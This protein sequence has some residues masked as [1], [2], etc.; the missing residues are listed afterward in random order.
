MNWL[1]RTLTLLALICALGLTAFGQTPIPGKY[2]EYYTVAKT[3][4]TY[5]DLGGALAGPSIN[6]WREVAFY[7][8][9]AVFTKGA[10]FLGTGAAAAVNFNP[11]ETGSSDI[12]GAT[13]QV[14][15]NHQVAAE[16]RIT[17]TS[18][19][20][21]SI[22]LYNANATDSVSFIA[23]GGLGRAYDAV[24][25]NASVNLGG[26]V[27]YTGTHGLPAKVLGLLQHGN[28]TPIE[29]NIVNGNPKPMI[30]DDG[31]VVFANGNAPNNQI[32]VYPPGLGNPI[33][34]AD[35]ANHW[36]SLDNDPGISRDGRIVAFQGNI[37]AV[38]AAAIG[39]TNGPGIFVAVN[40]GAGFG[41]AKIIRITGGKVEDVAADR[42]AGKGNFDGV[43][44]A[45]EICKAAAELG[46]DNSGNPITIASYGTDSRVGVTNVDFGA[47]GIDDDSFVI[48]FIAT[49]SSASRDNPWQPGS[50]LV[51]SANTGLWTIRVDVQHQLTGPLGRVY[52][53]FT[54]IPVVQVGD[55][56]GADTVTAI[57]VYDPIAN[58]AHDENGN[59]RTM[60]R[61]DHRVAFWVSTAAGGQMII[62]ANHL[63]SDQDGLLD[64][65]ETTG[66]DMDQ[67]GIVDLRL[68][69]YGADPFTRDL[70]LQVDWIGKP[71]SDQFKPAGG[72]FPSDVANAYSLFE[73]NLRNAEVLS[74]PMF[75]AR[76]DNSPPADIKAGIVPHVDA[77]TAIDSLLLPMSLNLG[78]GAPH[79][80]NYVG[81][82]GDPN[83][84]PQVV[85]FGQ[86][87][88]TVAGVNVR[89]FQDIKDHFLGG[90]D[91]A[92]RFLAFHYTVFSPFQDFLP[93]YPA[94]PYSATITGGDVSSIEVNHPAASF[95]R[96]ADGAFLLVTSG[97]AIGTVRQISSVATSGVTG[98]AIFALSASLNPAP[99]LGDTVAFLDGS[100]GLAEVAF[101]PD[102]DN[103]SLPGNDFII[104]TGSMGVLQGVPPNLC[105][106]A[107]TASHELGHTLGLL[108]GGIDQDAKK[109]GAVFKSV[110]S[111]TW[112]LECNP[113][114][115][116]PFYSVSGD[117]T[118]DNYQHL[119]FNFPDVQFHLSTSLGEARGEGFPGDL[120]QQTPEQTL[121]DFIAKNG[122]L[123]T[124]PPT[125]GISSPANASNVVAGGTLTVNITASDN[126]AVSRVSASFDINGNGIIEAGEAINAT[127]T[128]ANT[129]QAV[130]P[131]V[132]G[133]VGARTVSAIAFD[134]SSNS[135]R[136]AISVNVVANVQ[137]AVPNVVGLTQVAATNAITNAGLVVGNVTQASSNT[138]AAGS[139]ISE[140]PVAGTLVNGGSSVDLVISTGPAQVQVPNVVGLTQAAATTAITNAGLV[141]GT[142]SQASSNTVAA[143][144]VIS[145][146]PVAGTSVNLGS[147]VNIVVSTGPAQ[148]QVPNVVGLTQA[149]ATTA[150]TNAGLVLGT[151]SQASSNTVAA[152]NVISESPVAGTSV[153]VGSSVN[154]VVSTGPAQV[155]VPNVV[156]L[157]QA[158]ATTAI[159]NAGLVLGTVSQASSNTVAAGNVI[160][161]SPVAGT[162]V[163]VGSS[164][165][166]VVSTGPAQ[167]QVPNVVGLTQA[168]ATTAI[169]NAGLVLG[170]VSQ[171]SSNT[172]AAGNVI[173]ESPVAGT[174]VNVGSSVNIV[175]STGPAQ[176]QVPN[177][178]G[179]TQAAATTAITNA[180]LV[181]GTV[182]QAS[183]NT[184]A[185]GNVISESPVAGTSVNSGSSVNIVVSTGPAQVQ[186][187]NVVGLTQAAATTAITN[188]GLVLGTVSQAASNTVAAGSVISESPVAGT[189]V[190]SGSSVNI[191]VS[192]G[193]AQ[194]Q[195]PNVVGLTQAAA[196][197]AITNAGLVLGT[198][199]QASSNTVAAGNVISES[200]VAGT[201]VNTGS[202]VN[203][204]V[205]TGPAQVQVPNVVGLT[206]AAATT[207]ITN[208]G[209][210][211]GTVTQASSNTVAAGNVIS[212][213][214]VA[215][216]S[217]NTGSSVN[218]VVS[219]GPAQVQVPNVVG[220]TQ[221]AA[222]TA[223]T[224][225]GLVLGTVSQASSNTV[226]AGNVISESPVAGTSVNSGSSVNIVVSTGP[227]QVQ[228][229]NVVGLTQAAATTA[230][231]NAGLV[232]GTVTQ[233]SSNTVAAGNVISE[234]P[235]AGTSVNTGS[236]VNIVV[237]TGPAQVQVPNVVGLTQAAATTAITNAGLVLGTV[238][239][240]SSNTVAA[241]NVISESPVAGTSVNPGSAVNIVVSTGPSQVQVPNVVGL[242]QAAA[243]TAITNAGLTVGGVSTSS[244]NT[245]AA[246]KVISENPAAGTTVNSGSAVNLVISTGPQ[247]A[248]PNVVGFTQAAAGTV[249]TNA[250][251][252]VGAISNQSSNTVAAG[253]VIS[254]N[255]PAAT[256]VNAGTPVSLVIS[257]G[258]A[259]PLT[260]TGPAA[261]PVG[262]AGAPYTATAITVTG[263]TGLG[264]YTWSASGLP[265]NL[266]ISLNTGIISGTPLA[267]TVNPLTVQV[268]VTDSSL[269][270][271]SKTYSLTITPPLVITGPATLPPATVGSAYST[272]VTATGG[273][274]IYIWSAN[275]LPAGLAINNLTGA[276]TGTPTSNTGSP[277]NIQVNVT[278]RNFLT[279][280]RV[281]SLTVNPVL[282]ISAPATLPAG[283]AGAAYTPTTITATGG[284]GTYTWAATGLPSGLSIAAATGVI[285]GT[286]TSSAGTFNVT[287]TVTDSN[288]V[289]VN[290]GYT[291]TIAIGTL[292]IISS[293]T[294]SATGQ[295]NIA[296]NGWVSIYGTNFAPAGF[297]DVWDK[298][299]VGGK[300]PST[301]DG[302][303]AMID[304][305]AAYVSYVSSTQINVLAADVNV[306]NVTVTVTTSAGTSTPFTVTSQT[307][308]PA[309]FPWPGGQ[310]VATHQDFSPA[311]KN[312]S[313]G[314]STVPAKP[315]ETIILWGTGFGPTTPAIPIG[316]QVPGNATY[317]TTLPVTMTI[318][319]EN[320]A[321]FGTALASGFGGLYQVAVTVPADLPNGDYALIAKINGVPAA[322]VTL[323]VQKP[324]STEAGANLR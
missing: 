113:T 81:M 82:P 146:S 18:P 17:T 240:S 89:S 168:A 105:M 121:L 214:P 36:L 68:S 61:G 239:Q 2:Y 156:G 44:D 115:L 217:V 237:S 253:A 52:H 106:E 284:S 308:S 23:R 210:V 25:V 178:V 267:A 232:L 43:C 28:P 170:T 138:V 194:V 10:L 147:S 144:N 312:G 294:N 41:S 208:A 259:Q 141:L 183:S 150:I 27:V 120:Q 78:T 16:D 269:T 176:V 33:D 95:P 171:A 315:G 60:R 47:A 193:P 24:F 84:L 318:S 304:G 49:P 252:A 72:V 279:V 222:T 242:T 126:Q 246:G 155:Q 53:P 152:G 223:I 108:H 62:R 67:D 184:V 130:F 310:P 131:S 263:G 14:N 296:P 234:S 70:F 179:L 323:T 11:G 148:V 124:Q 56:L 316:V 271:V 200:P 321:V 225:A 29:Q 295:T 22:R 268:T 255:P 69:D 188:A 149:A 83:T 93:N 297:T 303:S 127:Q 142:V 272:T 110:M 299:I 128:G 247:I 198:V 109:P 153:N 158:A 172:V 290:R 191:V 20:T 73:T 220:L 65:W 245:V 285:S 143:G 112:Q 102:P 230:I 187:P 320:A 90:S 277:F 281:Y 92:A 137:V 238:T 174:S 218:I 196:T 261:L 133:P 319:N 166:I 292:P 64:H 159:T 46:F 136:A 264:T 5:T 274:G 324:S 75:G 185:A 167:V 192:T 251:L 180:G 94:I 286:P 117:A 54:P 132:G 63:D 189:S 293:V 186:V 181:L 87:G 262:T 99:G 162:S 140:N 199:S 231:T 86:P 42:A 104:S 91:K 243:T 48:S 207:A 79:G 276:I 241:G 258:P 103:N 118:T 57:A 311:A 154:I 190:N 175:V 177:V 215:G 80:G 289:S 257:T 34:I 301:V 226:A 50:P 283:T 59:I 250:G 212:E 265:A 12:I 145:E 309:F 107:E 206:Q 37:D 249:L 282:T 74:G 55:H 21:T 85:Y 163:N 229:P 3:G 100:T 77:G 139:V 302:V 216:T 314:V 151:V 275:G 195:V 270:S 51:F 38:G 219:T 31:T 307:Y 97:P 32:L 233:A 125:V 273:F 211:L 209:L 114:P 306:G 288:S 161:E 116:Q 248:V 256:L 287:V 204:V 119:Q 7:G 182:S 202:S 15:A 266:S 129:Y 13:V 40:E 291:I 205:S 157:T 8:T 169:T 317:N 76:V 19:A 26:D 235:V 9:T 160:S 101:A 244:S 88:E 298:F 228:V 213:S 98:N 173:S 313:L 134:T 30:A 322:T 4:A 45:G 1:S 6:D 123:D 236:S 122:P 221:A 164:V 66:I 305:K 58:A 111:Y 278:D 96:V 135:T 165:N 227:A 224:N 39:T 201:S 254:E 71:G 197:T 260:I 35:T 300:L 203:I 280:S